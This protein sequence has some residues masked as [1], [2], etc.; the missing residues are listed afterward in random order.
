MTCHR[1]SG[2]I[3]G[4]A[5]LTVTGCG[6]AVDRADAPTT[7]DPSTTGTTI[8]SS[9]TTEAGADASASSSASGATTDD[10]DGGGIKLDVGTFP[11][12]GGGAVPPNCENI[13]EFPATSVGC[14]FY[15]VQVPS[16]G[17]PLPYGISVG[18]PGDETAHVAIEDMRGPGGTLRT[19]VNVEVP[20]HG[21]VMTE[22]NGQGG[23]LAGENHVVGAALN[24]RAA[25]RVTSDVPVTAMQIFP[26]GGGPSHV[27]EASLLLPVNS[28][29]TAYISL[30]Y[31]QIHGNAGFTVVVAIEDATSVQTTQ[32]DVMLDQFDAWNYASGSDATGFF[33]SAD[34]PVAVF[35]GADCVLIPGLP[36]YACDH[37]EEQV[38][39]LSAWG[40]EYVGPRHP[41]RV[42]AINPTP[43]TVYWRVV[44]A[45]DGT[46]ITLEPPVAGNN[47]VIELAFLGEHY[48][49]DT[50]QSFVASSD[51][52]FML[53]Q[54]MSGCYNV[55]TETAQPSTCAQGAT[56]DPYM[57]QMVP[58]EQWLT[59][60]PF[61]TDYSYPR[62]FVTIVREAGTDVWLECLGDVPDGHFTPIPGTSYE[63]GH[64][65][66]DIEGQDGGEGNCVDG[67]QYLTATG[68]VGVLVG[69]VDWATSYGYPGGLSLGGLWT[70]PHTPPG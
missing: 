3:I 29:D 39:P 64:V 40:T 52:P 15:G 22:I 45:A 58:V 13:D 51:D 42:P 28:L 27:A 62:D 50:T 57:M 21:S 68:P 46:T 25:F 6:A 67:E 44:A 55:I 24:E 17:S 30:G 11:D 7:F 26:V 5:A 43:E 10:T 32:G 48:E 59:S 18:N 8:E 34:K 47:G 65:D 33:L 14:E 54:Y 38:I 23:V 9:T 2:R 41:H 60:L 31:P 1:S 56:G 37:I 69:G 53:V 49:F 61:L 4:L 63:V 20:P 36:W 12:L 16:F 70:P 19:I 35:S 66:L